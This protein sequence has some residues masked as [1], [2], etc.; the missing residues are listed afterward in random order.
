M[1]SNE[2]IALFCKKLFVFVSVAFFFAGCFLGVVKNN[3]VWFFLFCVISWSLNYIVSPFLVAK[4]SQV[5]RVNE[6][7]RAD[8]P[9]EPE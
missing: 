1:S 5:G 3:G 6:M 2:S 4:L 8:K 7:T 9:S